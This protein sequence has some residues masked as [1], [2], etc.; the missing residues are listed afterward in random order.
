MTLLAA[1]AEPAAGGRALAGDTASARG[2]AAGDQ[3]YP[4]MA[5]L[6]NGTLLVVWQ[7]RRAHDGW[8]D[9]YGAVV[10][11]ANP[12]A[13]APFPIATGN[14]YDF[15]PDLACGRHRCVVVWGEL[16]TYD[17]GKLWMRTLSLEGVPLGPA[18]E[19]G[20][21]G[22]GRR[23]APS[24]AF[25]PDGT[26]ALVTWSEG[27][28]IDFLRLGADAE[29]LQGPTVLSAVP[30]IASYRPRVAGTGST[31]VVAWT[32]EA[33]GGYQ[34]RLATVSPQTGEVGPMTVVDVNPNGSQVPNVFADAERALLVV[35]DI[36]MTSYGELRA[37]PLGQDGT[38]LADAGIAVGSS[39]HQGRPEAVFD[40]TDWVVVTAQQANGDF[41]RADR[42]DLAA[43]T[44]SF[45][46]KLPAEAKAAYGGGLA[47]SS[48]APLHARKQWVVW[49]DD[50]S[51]VDTDLY[52]ARLDAATFG[53]TPE[54]GV[55]L[56]RS[57]P[58]Q[59]QPAATPVKGGFLVAWLESP[60]P[61][62]TDVRLVRTG[63][64]GLP[65]SAPRT[66]VDG[67]YGVRAPALAAA[68]TGFALAWVELLPNWHELRVQRLDDFGAPIPG[69]GRR[70][71][72][73]LYAYPTSP[74][75]VRTPDWTWVL[76][77][78]SPTSGRRLYGVRTASDGGWLDA[79]P[80]SLVGPEPDLGENAAAASATQ[81][82]VA[83]KGAGIRGTRVSFEG[84][85]AN[86][87][88]T[89]V[90]SGST[91][92]AQPAVASDGTDFLVVWSEGR[93]GS[94]NLVGV[95]VRG[96]DGQP[97]G[98]VQVYVPAAE[99][100]LLWRA[101]S[102]SPRAAWDGRRYLV[103]YNVAGPDAGSDVRRVAVDA[104]GALLDQ[105][106][107][108]AAAGQELDGVLAT[109]GRGRTLYA[110]GAFDDAAGARRLFSAVEAAVPLG[111]RCLSTA[112]CLEGV[113]GSSGCCSVG[114][115]GCTPPEGL[116]PGGAEPRVLRVGCGC[117][118]AGAG[119]L[120]LALL[121]APLARRRRGAPGAGG[122][123]RGQGRVP[124]HGR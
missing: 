60:G 9:L 55:P 89:V 112:E 70:F 74:L 63:L 75:A 69:S 51:Y 5:A 88:D 50:R 38:L 81:L 11:P 49:M 68:P 115:S 120:L 64:D 66:V 114:G 71:W 97:T 54:A 107:V 34:L 22:K 37:W 41:L 28:E 58:A 48:L 95:V 36:Q 110:W 118:G 105:A 80:V 43:G 83:W 12:A 84:V 29:V 47:V 72:E 109:D 42:L 40:G 106:P 78:A 26:Q 33:V 6:P 24:V 10:D 27:G 21:P 117:G 82:Y 101:A 98:P 108:A 7:E 57:A 65:A 94:E 25:L 124:A 59:V 91:Y 67:G 1:C 77:A 79:E 99:T 20:P 31:F 52:L 23:S 14:L 46:G 8:P 30:G 56:F 32:H 53:L 62:R 16:A 15:E 90:L 113:C 92:T 13:A 45:V 3:L 2:L 85:S 86:D 111:A 119:P 121:A 96:S 35:L 116:P 61:L 123:G 93:D 44:S 104:S 102:L 18:V 73:A 87:Q 17:D 122:A 39:T 76:S 103:T 4:R 19:L 100:E